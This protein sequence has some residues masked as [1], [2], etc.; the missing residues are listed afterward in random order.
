MEEAPIKENS[1]MLWLVPPVRDLIFVVLLFSLCFGSLAGRLLRDGGTGWHIRTGQ[2]ILATRSVPRSDPFSLSTTGRPWFAWEWLYE[3]GLGAAYN[4][5]GL[6]GAVSVTGVLLAATF[7]WLFRIMRAR[8]ADLATALVFLLLALGTSAIHLYVRPHVV[9]WLFT[10]AWWKLLEDAREQDEPKHLI[11]LPALMVL[12]VNVHGGF[13]F[14]LGLLG[15]YLLEAVWRIWSRHDRLIREWL[16]AMALVSVA[17]VLGTFVNPYG[18]RLH[19]HIYKYLTDSFLMKHIQE[20]QAP[21]FRGFSE[22]FFAFMLVLTAAGVALV[23]KKPSLREILVLLFAGWSGFYA[24]RNLPVSSILVA[25]VAAPYLS[26]A[27]Q[28]Y[29]QRRAGTRGGMRFIDRLGALDAALRSGL[30]P[31]IAVALVLVATLRGGRIGGAHLMDAQFDS[32]RFPVAAMNFMEARG[33]KEPVFSPDQWGGYLIYR[34]YL[35]VLVDDRHDLYGD[36][37]F[38]QYLKIV[39][40]EPGWQLALN[41]TGAEYVLMPAGSPLSAALRSEPEWT[42]DYRDNVSVL[43]ERKR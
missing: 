42:E 30:W 34:N 16:R 38:K 13:L 24:S 40:V 11:W 29:F 8:G 43:L 27:W 15:I 17:S 10:L 25:V 21:N 9:S 31:A 26:Q 37:F 19:V 6:N 3:A 18:Y 22:L 7:A 12:W 23:P 4:L 36:E 5:A 41:R 14:G 28:D 20:F 39:G 32:S 33:I 2:R 35:G 1:W